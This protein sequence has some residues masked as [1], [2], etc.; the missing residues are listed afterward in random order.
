M[1]LGLPGGLLWATFNLGATSPEQYG[2]YYAWGE[3]QPNWSYEWNWRTYFYSTADG[4]GKLLLI[5]KY[6]TSSTLGTVDNL[7]TLQSSDDAATQQFGNGS[8]IPTKADWLE[9]L[10]NT[11]SKWIT[12]NDVYGRKLTSKKNGKSLFLPA[13]GYRNGSGLS[14]AGSLGL[15]WSASLNE[16]GPSH[17]WNM[18]FGSDGQ[19][20]L[21][22]GNR[23]LGQSV[24][25][26]RSQN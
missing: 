4:S 26:V 25:A 19:S 23:Y 11:T 7:T 24:R 17:A 12:L 9:L 22:Y 13:A 16:S 20:V 8:R 2:D 1:D 6:N 15:Y 10:D 18:Y 21:S 3:S 14:N 5:T